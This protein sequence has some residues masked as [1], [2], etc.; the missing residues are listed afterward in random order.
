MI[1]ILKHFKYIIV[2]SIFRLPYTPYTLIIIVVCI[3]IKLNYIN[4][5]TV[6]FKIIND[7]KHI[8][9]SKSISNNTKSSLKR[10]SSYIYMN[11]YCKMLLH[12]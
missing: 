8:K 4:S 7:G 5:Y 1:V 12:Y 6:Q 10:H 11:V 9:S 3:S 2:P